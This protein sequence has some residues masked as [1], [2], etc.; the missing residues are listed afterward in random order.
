MEGHWQ[1]NMFKLLRN[2]KLEFG[3]TRVPQKEKYR[4]ESLGTWVPN[5]QSLYRDNKLKDN[6]KAQLQ[7]IGFEWVRDERL[8]CKDTRSLGKADEHWNQYFSLLC[9]YNDEHGDTLVPL[10]H[11]T[12]LEDG[13]EFGLG[14][15]VC[16]QRMLKRDG[17]LRSE[18]EDKLQSI[19]FVF[20]IDFYNAD[21]S[22]HQKAWDD[23]FHRVCQYKKIHG[24]VDI[25]ATCPDEP[26]LGRWVRVQRYLHTSRGELAPNR[27]QR[28]DD[29]GFTWIPSEERWDTMV[30][31]LRAYKRNHGDCKVPWSYQT[32]D[33]ANLGHWVFT[34]RGAHRGTRDI[35]LGQE[36]VAQL[37]ALGF[38]W[39]KVKHVHWNV[40]YE[41]LKRYHET[42]GNCRVPQSY[43]SDSDDLPTSLEGV[44][45][46]CKS[47]HWKASWRTLEIICTSKDEKS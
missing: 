45:F 47:P 34:V 12:R 27:Y 32:C 41:A 24:N 36:K 8:L 38:I 25:P 43:K 5:Q 31:H 26:E 3:H 18:R 15:F 20:T 1:R 14:S 11:M 17:L 7:E 22:S 9:Q 28:L 46:R 33:G 13:D 2:Y 30:E 42:H 4:L 23:M 21:A 6:R 37:N 16:R 39:G 44:G 40:M 19:G 35:E 29:L 10:Q